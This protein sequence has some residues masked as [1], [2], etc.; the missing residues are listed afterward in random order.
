MGL[1]PYT[2]TA[3]DKSSPT[4]ADTTAGTSVTGIAFSKD[5]FAKIVINR[6][7]TVSQYDDPIHDLQGIALTMRF[8]AD[9]NY[10]EA[11][12]IFYHK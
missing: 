12:C 8:G 1:S 3:T 7:L 4:W 2:C 6:D 10:E 11:A 5:D 9:V